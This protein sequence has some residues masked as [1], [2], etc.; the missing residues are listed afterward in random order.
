MKNLVNL[1]KTIKSTIQRNKSKPISLAVILLLAFSSVVAMLP[2][3]TAVTSFQGPYAT[4]NGQNPQPG[5]ITTPPPDGSKPGVV[6]PWSTGG[7][8]MIVAPTDAQIALYNYPK[9][10][11]DT[12][13]TVAPVVTGVGQ[14]ESIIFGCW[15]G[16]PVFTPTLNGISGGS[17]GGWG[18]NYL[19]ITPPNGTALPVIG[20]VLSSDAGSATYVFMVDT[21]GLWTANYTFVGEL[22]NVTSPAYHVYWAPFTLLQNFTVQATPIPAFVEKVRPA[23]NEPFTLPVD[24]NNRAWYSIDGPWLIESYNLTGKFNPYTLAPRSAHILWNYQ[25]GPLM[26]GNIGGDYGALNWHYYDNH[27]GGLTS[28]EF[29]P[30]FLGI[31]YPVVMCG[32]LFADGIASGP[33]IQN[34]S[35]MEC[36]N[37]KTGAT[38]WTAPGCEDAGEIIAFSTDMTK[39]MVPLLWYIGAGTANYIAYDADTGRQLFQVSNVPVSP[40]STDGDICAIYN[41][42]VNE[43]ANSSNG[44]ALGGDLQTFNLGNLAGNAG[45]YLAV[46]SAEKMWYVSAH[47]FNT[48]QIPGLRNQGGFTAPAVIPW[49]DGLLYNNTF[50]KT[51]SATA[52]PVFATCQNGDAELITAKLGSITTGVNQYF[53]IDYVTGKLAWNTSLTVPP[54]SDALSPGYMAPN[55]GQNGVWT[56]YY[57][58]NGTLIGLSSYDGHQVWATQIAHNSFGHQ[59]MGHQQPQN[60]MEVLGYGCVYY[61]LLDGYMN[62]V[63]LTTGALIWSSHTTEGGLQMPEP[64]YPNMDTLFSW[65]Q[66]TL[67]DGLVFSSTGREHGILPQYQGDLLYAWNATTGDLVWNLTGQ[68]GIGAIADGVIVGVNQN[69]GTL[70]GIS[71]GPSQTTISAANTNNRWQPSSDSGNGN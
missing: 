47:T 55:E 13:F 69:E 24:S 56:T 19:T 23:V 51:T 44:F 32:Y 71:P 33:P 29:V 38:V 65:S 1:G 16:P 25:I 53:G 12:V 37:L 68:W 35:Y 39:T 59:T 54:F 17:Y 6:Y 5:I 31:S 46:W 28:S 45:T 48:I 70:A 67:A 40:L 60:A 7:Q 22:V 34:Y 9:I 61:M 20:P 52:Y 57:C 43:S 42:P 66:P 63:N 3:V 11:W 4:L 64:Y 10:T 58:D 26:G 14:T 30:T 41:G 2:Y 15:N 50:T 36:I 21:P 8:N 18:G 27:L 62:C 49:T